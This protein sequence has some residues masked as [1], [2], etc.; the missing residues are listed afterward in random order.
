MEHQPSPSE[1]AARTRVIGVLGGIASGKSLVARRLAGP[2]GLVLDADALAHEVLH[3]PEVVRR[4]VE[5]FGAGVLDAEG[6]PDRAALAQ[7]VF[8][9][10]DGDRARAELEG[11]IHPRVRARILARLDEARQ[12]GVPRV[13]LDVP[14]LL[15][16]DAQHG[17]VALCDALVLVDSDP[18]ERDRRAQETRAWEP[19]EVAR[20]EAVQIPLQEKRR[21]AHVHVTNTG[22]LADLERSIERAELALERLWS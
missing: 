3:S 13:V 9:P 16:N 11:W 7:R 14:L 22:T 20:R 1:D 18:A 12:S 19:G 2:T 4:I 6:K 15:E 8:D 5:R 10:V 17:L 21:R